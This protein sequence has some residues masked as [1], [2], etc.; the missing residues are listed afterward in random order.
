ME[1]DTGLQI[2]SDPGH[3]RNETKFQGLTRE[4]ITHALPLPTTPPLPDPN[5]GGDVLP[6]VHNEGWASSERRGGRDLRLWPSSSLGSYNEACVV[7]WFM[8]NVLCVC[9]LTVQTHDSD[10]I[11][12]HRFEWACCSM[13]K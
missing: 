5:I 11:R 6:A 12:F 8:F 10:A 9:A 4:M 1:G 13:W 3:C 2:T 7:F